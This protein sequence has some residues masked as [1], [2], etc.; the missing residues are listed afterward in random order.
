LAV[1]ESL[2]E[3]YYRIGRFLA[4]RDG[5][6]IEGNVEGVLK[7]AGYCPHCPQAKSRAACNETT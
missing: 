1:L 4:V 7:P 3:P 6:M 2:F 5:R